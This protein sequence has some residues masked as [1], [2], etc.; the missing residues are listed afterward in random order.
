M[1][2][3]SSPLPW[4]I[5]IE[6]DVTFDYLKGSN[7]LRTDV[8]LLSPIN[9]ANIIARHNNRDYDYHE[10][11]IKLDI[12]VDYEKFI[13]CLQNGIAIFPVHGPIECENK[14][15][16]SILI[17]C[18]YSKK[19]Y[20]FDRMIGY[21]NTTSAINIAQIIYKYFGCVQKVF[22]A[23]DN[24]YQTGGFECGYDSLRLVEIVMK[25]NGAI[26]VNSIKEY[27]R[28]NRSYDYSKCE[29]I[30]MFLDNEMNLR[31]YK[32]HPL[33]VICRKRKRNS[34]M[35]EHDDH[36]QRK[37]KTCAVS[38]RNRLRILAQFDNY[39]QI[40]K[41]INGKPLY[42][43]DV[44]SINEYRNSGEKKVDYWPHLMKNIYSSK[45]SNESAKDVI[46]M[47]PSLQELTNNFDGNMSW[48]LGDTLALYTTVYQE[49][50]EYLIGSTGLQIN[51]KRNREIKN[52]LEKYPSYSVDV[53]ADLIKTTI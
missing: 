22:V 14:N 23:A 25:M 9:L 49:D 51:M 15:H 32:T 39:E 12:G 36:I 44:A 10:E 11:K 20:H 27:G 53:L 40:F 45:S 33:K 21:P 7:M 47:H 13:D 52:Y 18:S 30:R 4:L 46:E 34:N 19:F 38:V 41:Q 48:K 17:Y 35:A 26:N 5:D 42:K 1:D 43:N 50:Y 2:Y 29:E 8:T 3:R 37:Y 31:S 16:W 24:G 6:F 28:Q